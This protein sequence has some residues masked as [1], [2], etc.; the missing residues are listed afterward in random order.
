MER[1]H[2]ECSGIIEEKQPWENVVVGGANVKRTGT[3]GEYTRKGKRRDTDE[4]E[5]HAQAV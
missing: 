1:M 4:E 3:I 2:S 5:M